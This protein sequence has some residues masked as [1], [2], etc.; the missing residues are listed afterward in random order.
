M[1]SAWHNWRE[2]AVAG[3][4]AMGASR[5]ADAARHWLAADASLA[6]RADDP[7][8]V[9]PS[10]LGVA[11]NN[12]GVGNLLLERFQEA[13]TLL[14]EAEHCWRQAARDVTSRD[15]ELAG[16]SSAFHFRLASHNLKSFE[17]AQRRR[18]LDRC[19]AGLTICRLN[20]LF[21]SRQDR[22]GAETIS[23]L[24]GQLIGLVGA[25]APEAR[26][27]G[28]PSA[29]TQGS[30]DLPYAEIAELAT[31]ARPVTDWISGL[32]AAVSLTALLRPSLAP[33]GAVGSRHT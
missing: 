27:L 6:A 17:E 20:R 11:H 26:L 7:G 32:A 29:H 13:E 16:R 25:R 23:A 19:E 33:G 9:G 14:A 3:F 10:C 24:A 12:A 28:P 8:L 2:A 1:G 5:H 30:A 15:V 4:Q 31:R 21:A 18:L 22:P